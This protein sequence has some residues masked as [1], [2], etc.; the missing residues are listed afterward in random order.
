MKPRDE[1][2]IERIYKATL[3]LVTAT[4]L[5]GITMQ[6]VAK[7]AKIATGTLYIYFEN[8]ESLIVA[9]FHECIKNS[10]G[11]FFRNYDIN[12]PFKVGFQ[13]IWSNVLQHRISRFDESLFMEQCFHSP[14][15]DEQTKIEAKKIFEPL[16]DLLVRGKK[17][18]LIKD[19]DNF[20]LITFMI[21]NINEIAKRANY[22]NKKLSP[23]V[24]YLNFQLCWD[25]IKA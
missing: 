4:G 2:K 25:G 1:N 11:I 5:A 8:K 19:I 15:I 16:R 20:W 14:F 18:H 17:E 7:E 21:G 24:K 13:T 9:L 23:D 10:Q 3:K 12:A 6:A 22:F